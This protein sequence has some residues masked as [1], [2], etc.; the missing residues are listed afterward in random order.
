MK[1]RYYAEVLVADAAYHGRQALTYSSQEPLPVGRLVTV[2]LRNKRVLGIVTA[3]VSKPS[4]EVKPIA[5]VPPLSALPPATIALLQWMLGYYPAPLGVTTSL[6]LPQ[7]LPKDLNTTPAQNHPITTASLPP[8]TKDQRQAL[9]AIRRPGLHVLHGETGTGKTRVYIELAAKSFAQGTSALILTP[10]IG[11][12]SQLVRDF[13]AVFG[14]RVWLLHSK[15]TA[16]ARQRVWLCALEERK[17]VI[18]IGPRSALFSPLRNIGLIAV[19]ESHE[20]AYKQDNAPYYHASYVAAKLAEL[21]EATLVLGSATPSVTDYAIAAAK[22]RPIVRLL[23]AATATAPHEYS[24]H[25]VDARD[26][27][28]FVTSPYLSDT[29]IKHMQQTLAKREQVLLFL[30]RRGTA[31]VVFCEQCGWQAVCPHCDLPLVYH[32]DTHRMRCHTCAYQA[33]SPSGCPDCQ[34]AAIVFKSIGTKALVEHV[35]KLFPGSKTQRFDT[36]NKSDE[37]FEKHFE[38]IHRGDIDIIVGTQ[39]IAKGIDLPK[40]SLVGVVMADSSLSFPDFSASERTYQLLCQ[41]IGRIGRGHRASTAVI[42]TYN[43]DG[44]ILSAV[45]AKDWRAFYEKELG[46]RRQFNFPPFCHVL[47]LTCRRASSAAAARASEQLAQ[48]L[49]ALPAQLTIEGPAPS[50]HERVQNKYQWQLIVKAKRRADLVE[51]VRTLPANW[52][53]D[54]DPLNLL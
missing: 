10:E 8:L 6:F 19:D 48:K 40:L 12:T 47:K 13:Q 54:I 30:N 3:N 38:S 4:F 5:D 36:D 46:E 27:K 28:K 1:P 35:T 25:V 20:A 11:L 39:T 24:M 49:R 2:P 16:S 14:D 37:R 15:L 45:L 17:P 26:R 23:Q 7:K 32:G 41:V 34:N 50:F 22:R 44:S 33:S 18:V 31:R 53:Y 52:L 21:H 42:Q 29:L 51:I 9:D 43:P